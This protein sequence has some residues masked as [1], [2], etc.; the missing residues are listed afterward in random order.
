MSK[1]NKSRGG[2]GNYQNT[3]DSTINHQGTSNVFDEIIFLVPCYVAEILTTK[4][5]LIKSQYQLPKKSTI[6][7]TEIIV[8]PLPTYHSYLGSCHVHMQ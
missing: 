2:R 4:Q 3:V 1:S 7:K 5:N 6:L 8:Y